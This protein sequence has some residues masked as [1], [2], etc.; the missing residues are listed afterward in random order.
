MQPMLDAV[1]HSL[2]LDRLLLTCPACG[3][4]RIHRSHPR[5]RL[6]ALARAF[7]PL[8]FHRCGEC[9]LR[10]HHWAWAV[11]SATRPEHPAQPSSRGRLGSR[12]VLAARIRRRRIAI[13]ITVATLLGVLASTVAAIR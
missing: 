11:A 7:T 3:A 13:S 8:R 2:D 9:G 12:D 1:Q 5:N 6:E 4:H 10:G